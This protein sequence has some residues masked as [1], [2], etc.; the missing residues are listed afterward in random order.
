MAPRDTLWLEGWRFFLNPPLPLHMCVQAYTQ[1]LFVS[2]LVFQ[3]TPAVDERPH[4]QYF[5][6]R[7][8]F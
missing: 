1:T 5:E 2:T 7:G 4:A 6:I 3:M 8:V